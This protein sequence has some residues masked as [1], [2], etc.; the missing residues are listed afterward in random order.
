MCIAAGEPPTANTGSGWLL[1]SSS[2]PLAVAVSLPQRRQGMAG[3]RRLRWPIGCTLRCVGDPL[4]ALCWA[5]TVSA[6]NSRQE[7]AISVV[8]AAAE[9]P[10]AN[11]IA[12]SGT[13]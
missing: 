12:L 6:G 11:Q 9:H 7:P 4:I 3:C 1:A 8:E 2:F 10:I 13:S 5:A